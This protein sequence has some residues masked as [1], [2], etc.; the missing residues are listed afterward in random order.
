MNSFFNLRD[1][2]FDNSLPLIAPHNNKIKEPPPEIEL[3]P[4]SESPLWE[5]Y[6][7]NKNQEEKA[8]KNE[9]NVSDINENNTEKFINNEIKANLSNSINSDEKKD[10]RNNNQQNIKKKADNT[11]SEIDVVVIQQE[12]KVSIETK[13]NI[14]SIQ[15]ASLSDENMVETEWLRLKK[16]FS[17][18]LEGLSYTTKKIILENKAVFYRILA[19]RFK[20]KKVAKDFC[21]RLNQFNDCLIRKL[22]P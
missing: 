10:K 17:P 13:T 8:K 3:F 21:I 14:Y 7:S 16:K 1:N 22:E 18:E 11:K 9:E 15:L 20:T 19:G 2:S 4:N 6:K 12:K 5:N